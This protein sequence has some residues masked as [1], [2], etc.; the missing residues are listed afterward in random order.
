MIGTALQYGAAV[1]GFGAVIALWYA[2]REAEY[3]RYGV[4]LLGTASLLA[5]LALFYLVN[6]F[7]VTDYTNGYVWN[8][9]A[10]YLSTLYRITGVYAGVEG[11]LLLWATLVA[12]IAYWVVRS[13]VETADERL[14]AAIVTTVATVILAYSITRTPFT[15]L[16]ISGRGTAFGPVGLNPLLKSPYMIIHPP[17]TFAGYAL[18]TV[19]FA[20]GA[21]HFIRKSRGRDGI[22]EQRLPEATRWLRLAWWF[23]TAA[24]ALGALWSYTTLGWGGLWAWDPVETAILVTWLF[25][26]AAMHAVS[27]YRLRGANPVLAPAMATLTLPS[28]IFA[29][30]IT[31]SGT[32]DL[33]SF[34]S[35]SPT[36]LVVLLAVSLAIGVG[37]PF[38]VWIRRP[39]SQTETTGILSHHRLLY[40]GI[41]TI[42]LLTFVSFWGITFP[43]LQTLLGGPEVSVGVDFYNMW[44]FPLVVVVLLAIGF[45]NDFDVRGEDAGRLLGAVVVLSLVAAVIP[46]SEWQFNPAKTGGYYG[47]VG[48]LNALSLFP[49]AA[50]A[51]GAT[52]S[53]LAVRLPSLP[54]RDRQLTLGGVGLVHIGLA[55]IVLATPFTYMFAVSGS[56]M[57]PAVSMGHEDGVTLD[58]SPYTVAVENYSSDYIESDLSLSAVEREAVLDR[59]DDRAY[60]ADSLPESASGDQ[61]VYGS[62]TDLRIEDGTGIAQLD[63]SSVWVDVGPAGNNT[64]VEGVPIYAQGTINRSMDEMTFVRTDGMFV[65]TQP[66]GAIVPDSR[67]SDR[68]VEFVVSQGN[69]TLAVGSTDVETYLTYGAV[70]NPY[71]DRGLFS[72][73]YVAAKQVQFTGGMPVVYILVKEVPLMSVVRFGIVLLLLGGAMLAAATPR[74]RHGGE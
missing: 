28:A 26:T 72:D 69:E 36:V 5:V 41:L 48:S 68:E 17:V 25:V 44:S 50:Y 23:L 14:V 38:Y 4:Y 74:S 7:L 42:G 29:R 9:T 54:D 19:P 33:H 65:G 22:F 18:T 24:V 13:G 52:L 27:N 39:E 32:S 43:L 11:S 53:R 62:I 15:A 3:A 35:G 34:A 58:E 37:L 12:L 10:D 6:Q 47:L 21:A 64:S 66:T 59:I 73:T 45:Y 31:Q 2:N 16:D 63:N 8:H 40:A 49:P 30:V 60:R 55:V 20:I 67:A 46:L 1:A 57:V 70:A 61:I 56:G 51:I 71:V